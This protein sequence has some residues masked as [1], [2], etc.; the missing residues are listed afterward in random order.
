MST[1][2]AP[3]LAALALAPLLARSA[4]VWVAGSTEKIR[5]DAKP[6]ASTAASL[7]AAK[8][9]FEA[10]QIVV[11]G[12]AAQVSV[13]ASPLSDGASSISDGAASRHSALTKSCG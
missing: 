9:E 5:P 13:E 11:T 10:F 3:L 4:D 7:E 12:R 6:R 1:R 2:R 8:N